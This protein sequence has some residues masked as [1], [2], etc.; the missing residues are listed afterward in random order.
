[1]I[2]NIKLGSQ[3]KS[4]LII[5]THLYLEAESEKQQILLTWKP[6]QDRTMQKKHIPVLAFRPLRTHEQV[7][8]VL[9]SDN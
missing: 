1:M 8:R 2:Q 4:P 3:W 6:K 5:T 7:I 9:L